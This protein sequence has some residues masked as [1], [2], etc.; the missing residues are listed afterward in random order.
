MPHVRSTSLLVSP[1]F[2]L[3]RPAG[4]EH[5][6]DYPIVSPSEVGKMCVGTKLYVDS[7]RLILQLCEPDVGIDAVPLDG[8]ENNVEVKDIARPV[9][10]VY[11]FLF[12][13]SCSGSTV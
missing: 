1:P 9:V 13:F 11:F 7:E 5:N 3:L 4:V 2:I 8:V 12:F 10:R 6:Q